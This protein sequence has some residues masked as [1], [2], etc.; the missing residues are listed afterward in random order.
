MEKHEMNVSTFHSAAIKMGQHAAGPAR[1]TVYTP[2]HRATKPL[3]PPHFVR[4]QDV[5]VVTH[6]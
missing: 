3:H 1:G 5:L 2:A 6:C 4:V